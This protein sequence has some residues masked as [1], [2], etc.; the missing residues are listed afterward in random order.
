MEAALMPIAQTVKVV[1]T[2]RR[3]TYM[4]TLQVGE[5]VNDFSGIQPGSLHRDVLLSINLLKEVACRHSC[6][7]GGGTGTIMT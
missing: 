7:I 5:G 6:S 4:V 3:C 1:L 2:C